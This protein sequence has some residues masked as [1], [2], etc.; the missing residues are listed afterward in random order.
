MCQ[1][2]RKTPVSKS[3]ALEY[4]KLNES[5]DILSQEQIEYSVDNSSSKFTDLS[6]KYTEKLAGF[7]LLGLFMFLIYFVAGWFKF[8]TNNNDKNYEP[9]KTFGHPLWQDC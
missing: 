2:C 7:V 6:K 5:K 1:Y 3:Q 9:C 4:E 8:D